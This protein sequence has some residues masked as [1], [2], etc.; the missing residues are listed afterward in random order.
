M[1]QHESHHLLSIQFSPKTEN[2]QGNNKTVDFTLPLNLLPLD[3]SLLWTECAP[4]KSSYFES[5]SSN[6]M[7]FGGLEEVIKF[8]EGHETSWNT[9]DGI[10]AHIEKET[11]AWEGDHLQAWMIAL[12]SPQPCWYPAISLL[13]S[14]LWVSNLCYLSHQVSGISFWQTNL[15]HSLYFAQVNLL[16]HHLHNM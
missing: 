12:T 9:H 7:V 5:L 14:E 3:S 8:R 4:R 10:T 15:R 16:L 6:G 1:T 11:W 13:A 2:N